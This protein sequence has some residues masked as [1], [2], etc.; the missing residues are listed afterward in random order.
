MGVKLGWGLWIYGLAA[1]AIIGGASAITAGV[2]APA[3]APGQFNYSGVAGWNNLKLMAVMALINGVIG[4][5]AYLQ[6]TPLPQIETT[7]AQST[8]EQAG[9]P[10]KTVTTVSATSQ[11]PKS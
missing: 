10:T 4:A 5:A 6:K 3:L 8:I 9:Q 11:E 7:V 2:A 1:A